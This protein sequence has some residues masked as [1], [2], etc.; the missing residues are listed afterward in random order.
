MKTQLGACFDCCE[1]HSVSSTV[2]QITAEYQPDHQPENWHEKRL[3]PGTCSL[4]GC[5][6]SH[7]PEGA[8]RA[9]GNGARRL[10]TIPCICS[11]CALWVV[12][13]CNLEK[14]CSLCFTEIKVLA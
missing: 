12:Y 1:E 4:P 10:R 13:H 2:K 5:G 14:H 9:A 8:A 6:E 11:Y 7:L 3:S